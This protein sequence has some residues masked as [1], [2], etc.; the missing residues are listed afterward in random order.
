MKKSLRFYNKFH[1]E[2][3]RLSSSHFPREEQSP[4][5]T[6]V[7]EQLYSNLRYLTGVRWKSFVC[8]VSRN[9]VYA[10]HN[11]ICRKATSFSDRKRKL[12]LRPWRKMMF[13]PSVGNTTQRV[14][15]ATV[16]VYIVRKSDGG[17][18]VFWLKKTKRGAVSFFR[19]CLAVIVPGGGGQGGIT[20]F[21]F[22][23]ASVWAAAAV[24]NVL[25]VCTVF[26][27]VNRNT[28]KRARKG[29]WGKG[30]AVRKG[31]AAHAFK[32]FWQYHG[33]KGGASLKATI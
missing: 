1:I 8:D 5:P 6:R 17:C 21:Y 18:L 7:A 4:S 14:D 31:P 24:V 22:Y 11:I 2:N 25:K 29:Y 33:F 9:I 28:F 20:R 15:A 23:F 30:G 10:K 19:V 27:G 13:L 16:S 12:Y 26:E 32:P 3:S